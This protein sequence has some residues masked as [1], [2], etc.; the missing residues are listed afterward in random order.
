[1]TAP[2]KFTQADVRRAAAGVQLA[3][4]Q[5]AKIVIDPNGKIEIIPG[6]PKEADRTNEWSDLD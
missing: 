1:M 5:I 2:A 6:R 3:G 4:L